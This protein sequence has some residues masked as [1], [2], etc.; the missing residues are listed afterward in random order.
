MASPPIRVS[1]EYVEQNPE[2]DPSATEVVINAIVVGAKLLEA[3]DGVLRPHG[4]STGSFNL[5]Q[6]VAGADEP[7]TPTEIGRRAHT[8]VT[9]ATI[10]GLLDTC[11][12]KALVQRRQHPADGRRVLVHLTPAGRAL[13]G[14]VG[15]DV[16]AAERRWIGPLPEPRRQTLLRAL[17]ELRAAL[18]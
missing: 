15:R 18:D 17:G 13:L 14:V 3:M 6:I 4:L 2:A 7:L 10:T 11:E 9:T 1:A 8:R 12:R 16:A 5:L